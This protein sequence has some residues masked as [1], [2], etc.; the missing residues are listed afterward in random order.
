M[1][2]SFAELGEMLNV[3]N[4]PQQSVNIMRDFEECVQQQHPSQSHP[5]DVLEIAMTYFQDSPQAE[6]RKRTKCKYTAS[7]TG[8]CVRTSQP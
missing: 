1:D 8:Q 6:R 7:S 3:F 5:P 4:E 2:I